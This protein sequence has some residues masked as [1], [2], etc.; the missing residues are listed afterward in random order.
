V[1]SDASHA[2]VTEDLSESALGDRWAQNIGGEPASRCGPG[3]PGLRLRL[4]QRAVVARRVARVQTTWGQEVG[5]V[6]KH[7]HRRCTGE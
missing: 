1:L 5:R 3:R 4:V 6:T 2:L 7:S